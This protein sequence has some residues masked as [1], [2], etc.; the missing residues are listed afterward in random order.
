M[1]LLDYPKRI[2]FGVPMTTVRD[3]HEFDVVGKLL[4]HAF[5]ELQVSVTPSQTPHIDSRE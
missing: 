1:D 2:L 5:H 3:C 4:G